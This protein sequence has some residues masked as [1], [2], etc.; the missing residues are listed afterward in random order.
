MDWPAGG[1]DRGIEMSPETESS[2]RGT[3]GRVGAAI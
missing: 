2:E 1:E 3:D